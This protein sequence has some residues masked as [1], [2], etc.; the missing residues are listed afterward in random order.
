MHIQHTVHKLNSGHILEDYTD[1]N[2]AFWVRKQ[3]RL[4]SSGL[5]I[6]LYRA[7]SSYSL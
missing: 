5:K 3:D 4:I 7:A 1:Q 6:E 2:V